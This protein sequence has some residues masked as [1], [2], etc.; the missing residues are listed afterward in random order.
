MNTLNEDAFWNEI[1]NMMTPDLEDMSQPPI[2]LT[3]F[4]TYRN[5]P[6]TESLD[7]PYVP[8]APLVPTL[9][10]IRAD[11]DKLVKKYG[12]F[13]TLSKLKRELAQAW[14]STY[15]KASMT[16]FQEFVKDNISGVREKHSDLP[17]GD[18]MKIIGTMWKANKPLVP[19]VTGLKRRN[20]PM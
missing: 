14:E 11:I 3:P 9:E 8:P 13:V 19:R 16:K 7:L 20:A 15:P 17:H 18:I 2:P 10:D 5:I 6:F 4:A 12:D 1:E